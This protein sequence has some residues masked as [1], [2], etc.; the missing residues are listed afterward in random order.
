MIEKN[1]CFWNSLAIQQVSGDFHLHLDTVI[2][3]K[4]MVSARKGLERRIWKMTCDLP[5]VWVPLLRGRGREE[6]RGSFELVW[7]YAN[8]VTAG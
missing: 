8:K 6:E 2:F 3:S 4:L 1:N 7:T 5:F